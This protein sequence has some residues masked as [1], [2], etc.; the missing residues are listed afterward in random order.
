[1]NYARGHLAGF[2]AKL[3][4]GQKDSDFY[5]FRPRHPAPAVTRTTS[6][7]SA[8]SP[9]ADPPFLLC[10]STTRARFQI[11]GGVFKVPL[12]CMSN[13]V[14]FG[15]DWDSG[16]LSP[17]A[18]DRAGGYWPWSNGSVTS[19]RRGRTNTASSTSQNRDTTTSRSSCSTGSS[20]SRPQAQSS[21]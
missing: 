10:L 2:T 19:G 7:D 13:G 18:T 8:H 1:M 20:G 14:L 3:D 9:L 21:C 4:R 15:R 5:P 11:R 17:L 12:I 6:A 16:K